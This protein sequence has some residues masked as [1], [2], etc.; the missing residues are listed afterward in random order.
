MTTKKAQKRI[1]EWA[2]KTWPVSSN[3]SAEEC[4]RKAY[5]EFGGLNCSVELFRETLAKIGFVPVHVGEC[6]ILRLPGPTPRLAE[7]FLKCEGF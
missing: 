2:E 1:A 5:G 3:V 4:I 6:F 7:Q